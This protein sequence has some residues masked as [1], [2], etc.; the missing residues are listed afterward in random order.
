MPDPTKGEGEKDFVSRFM[1]S[2]EARRDFPDEKQR[3]AVAYSKYREAHKSA[4]VVECSS[5]VRKA[6]DSVAKDSKV[7]CPNCKGKGTVYDEVAGGKVMCDSCGGT[8]K[9]PKSYADQFK[10]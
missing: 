1:Y 7:I 9:V 5:E 4:Q 10:R 6:V 8:G 3:A 2:A